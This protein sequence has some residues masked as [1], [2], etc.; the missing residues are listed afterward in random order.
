M[1]RGPGRIPDAARALR[2]HARA[3]EHDR[4]GAAP[5]RPRAR[6]RG[7]GS[8]ARRQPGRERDHRRRRR[9]GPGPVGRRRIPGRGRH[10]VLP[11]RDHQPGTSRRDRRGR[12]R[13]A[14]HGSHPA[15]G[16]AHGRIRHGDRAVDGGRPGRGRDAG[17][18]SDRAR[19]R[20]DRRVDVAA[21]RARDRPGSGRPGARQRRGGPGS[22]GDR[23]RRGAR[24]GRRD[25]AARR[26]AVPAGRGRGRAVPGTCELVGGAGHAGQRDPV[27][28]R[29]RHGQPGGTR[30][31][32]GTPVPLAARRRRPD[33]ARPARRSLRR[34]DRHPRR[35]APD[36][37]TRRHGAAG[38]RRQRGGRR[39]RRRQ[40]RV[41][42][43][44]S[45][46]S[47]LYEAGCD[48]RGLAAGHRV[49]SLRRRLRGGPGRGGARGRGRAGPRRH[50]P[51]GVV[52]DPARRRL[53]A[54]RAERAGGGQPRHRPS[55]PRDQRG[56]G[57]AGRR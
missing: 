49:H 29:R 55:R 5:R 27:Q 48:R 28:R 31:V 16:R 34:G 19:R 17:T 57:L 26:A 9:S 2:A 46:R 4:T 13:L 44:R 15:R 42:S 30:R 50:P 22:R 12:P 51:P 47:R 25:R 33:P 53:R 32:L 3:R 20:T 56:P 7:G 18:V 23:A 21:S 36:P 11:A 45:G 41:V 8:P 39:P 24:A 1:G 38:R 43:Q 14:R 37:G 40:L 10:L 35:P 6:R 52:G 54:A